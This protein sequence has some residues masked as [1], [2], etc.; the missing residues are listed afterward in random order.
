MAAFK[1]ARSLNESSI[2]ENAHHHEP[3]MDMLTDYPPIRIVSPAGFDLATAQTPGSV[4]PA[5][6]HPIGV[7]GR[8]VPGQVG[9]PDGHPSSRRAADDRLCAV[10]HLRSP[11]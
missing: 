2:C 7:V 9:S 4:R 3:F 6:R 10:G 11:L 8:T 1:A 5:A